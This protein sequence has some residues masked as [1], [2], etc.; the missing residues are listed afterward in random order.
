MTTGIVSSLSGLLNDSRYL[1]ISAGV[2]S[3]KSGGPLLDTS[4][5][6]VGVVTG[7]LNALKFARAT[8]E[9]T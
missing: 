2:K 4:G 5:N 7:K 3:G 1:Q 6:V 8:G 9:N